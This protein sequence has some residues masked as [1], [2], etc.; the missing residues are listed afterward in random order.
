MTNMI[1]R[2][3]V[4]CGSRLGVNQEYSRAAKQV[5]AALARRGIGLV[6]GGSRLG[7]MGDVAHAALD[8]GGEVVGV[9]PGNLLSREIAM[10]NLTQLHVVNNMAERKTMMGDLSDAFIVLPGGFGTL[11]ELFEMVTLRQIGL[12]AKP[13][14]LLNTAGYYNHLLAFVNH[15]VADGFADDSHSHLI[16][17]ANDA[18]AMV[19]AMCVV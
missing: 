16:R 10:T 19:D 3:C 1:K 18:E 13:I 17:V 7:L 5:G 11:D 12:S 9:I 2:I 15:A 14:G 8:A 4:F 6:Y